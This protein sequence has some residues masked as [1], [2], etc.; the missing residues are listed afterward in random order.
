M[1]SLQELYEVTD[2]LT[3][4]CLYVD[5]EPIGFEEAI[6]SKKWRQVMDEEIK[7]IEKND[8]WELTSL[9]K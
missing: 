1:R 6:Q 5:C 2:E 4:F 3:L 8:T 7:S 9:P